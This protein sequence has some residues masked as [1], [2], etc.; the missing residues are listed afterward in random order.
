MCVHIYIYVIFTC[1]YACMYMLLKIY[2][3]APH[4]CSEGQLGHFGSYNAVNAVYAG[5]LLELP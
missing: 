4:G 2:A 5:N 3:D 1:I